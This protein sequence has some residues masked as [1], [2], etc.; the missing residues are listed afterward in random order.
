MELGNGAGAAAVL[1]IGFF[2]G[3]LSFA[4]DVAAELD[5]F[6]SDEVRITNLLLEEIGESNG[7]VQL[8]FEA[9]RNFRLKGDIGDQRIQ[10]F[11]AY[12]LI[13][14]Q[15]AGTRLRAVNTIRDQTPAVHRQAN[16]K[17][18]GCRVEKGRESSCSTAGSENASEVPFR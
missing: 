16:S 12:A 11:L 15:N 18:T 1:S 14:E 8:T 4:P 6:G 13:N 7:E 10:R 3:Y 5:P 17:G 9:A 2:V